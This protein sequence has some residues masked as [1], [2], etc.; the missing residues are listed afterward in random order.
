MC[1]GQ[2]PVKMA[3]EGT[4]EYY[5]SGAQQ[6]GGHLARVVPQ[7]AA[8]QCTCQ[9]CAGVNVFD[10]DVGGVAGHDVPQNTAAYAGHHA[11]EHQKEEGGAGIGMGKKTGHVCVCSLD[12][13][14][15]EDTKTR[16]IHPEH[17]QVEQ[18][19][20]AHQKAAQAG[21]KENQCR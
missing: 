2:I 11:H 17:A 20:V 6:H 8:Q 14:D 5:Q 1:T 4:D 12:A 7:K 21:Q 15:G 19:G 16:R 9:R 10:E 3:G 13:G 18:S